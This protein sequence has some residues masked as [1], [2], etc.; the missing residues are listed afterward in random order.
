MIAG[1]AF[2]LYFLLIHLLSPN[3]ASAVIEDRGFPVVPSK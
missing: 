1:S 3:L 2:L